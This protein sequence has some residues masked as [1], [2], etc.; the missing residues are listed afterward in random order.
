MDLLE[1]NTPREKWQYLKDLIAEN[2]RAK[3]RIDFCKNQFIIIRKNE[4]TDPFT[5]G[6]IKS[7]LETLETPI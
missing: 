5:K 4:D 2:N 7:V 6:W 1:G 3:G